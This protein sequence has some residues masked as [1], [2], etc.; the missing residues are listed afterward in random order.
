MWQLEGV[1]Q[2]ATALGTL[3]HCNMSVGLLRS[4]HAHLV[5]IIMQVVFIVLLFEVSV[6]HCRSGLTCVRC[7]KMPVLPHKL[8]TFN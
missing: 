8:S 2:G 1:M 5:D 7:C 3:A 4:R 6:R